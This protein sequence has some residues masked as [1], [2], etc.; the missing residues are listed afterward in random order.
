MI[1]KQ[2][3]FLL[4]F[5]IASH[6]EA[7]SDNCATATAITECVI[8]NSTNLG[9]TTGVDDLYTPVEIC[10]TSIDNSV[11][12]SFVAS[13]TGP[14]TFTITNSICT[15]STNLETGIFSG[16][17]GSLTSLNCDA[18]TGNLATVFNATAGNTYFI[19]VDGINGSDCTFDALIC[20]GCNITAAFLPSTTTGAYP[21]SVSFTNLST[22]AQF[23]SWDFGV[24]ASGFDG[25]NGAFTYTEPGT[26]YV[27][28][29]TFN[30]V[31]TDTITDTIV[32][33]G[34]CAI[35][36]PNVFTPNQ[37][38]ENDLF[39]INCFGIKSLEVQIFNRWGEMVGNWIG[40]NGWWD[41]YSTMAGIKCA[42]GAY[43][44]KVIAEG[45]DGTAF[46]EKGYLQLFR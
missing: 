12:F 17:C 34:P 11:W 2:I 20:P 1:K 13:T 46:D 37:D 8:F 24:F 35:E 9:A 38:G 41:G 31:C 44:Y 22:G 26:F 43:F 36:I 21:L 3:L 5:F 16:S 15:G 45:N 25:T 40:N 6:V 14:Y 39:K 33:T 28:L 18:N 27:T 32:V 42:E 4:S 23:S 29:T 7:Q 19:V 10:A 30:G